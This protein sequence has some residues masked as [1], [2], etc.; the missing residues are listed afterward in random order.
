MDRPCPVVDAARDCPP[1]AQDRDLGEA[2]AGG[3]ARRDE[4]RR[5]ALGDPHHLRDL[6]YSNPDVVAT[7]ELDDHVLVVVVLVS[8]DQSALEGVAVHMDLQDVSDARPRSR[9]ELGGG[10]AVARELWHVATT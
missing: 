4:L 3:L 2:L 8:W 10:A 5:L 7:P 9:E 1:R 6:L